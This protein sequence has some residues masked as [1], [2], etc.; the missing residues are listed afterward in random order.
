MHYNFEF[1]I[2]TYCQAKCPSCART[3]ILNSNSPEQLKIHHMDL[4]KFKAIVKD[5]A[6]PWSMITF[7]GEHGDPMMHPQIEDFIEE[8]FK[9][10]GKGV[11]VCTNGGLRNEIFY[12]KLAKNYHH[13]SKK[14]LVLL[15]GIDGSTHKVNN[16]YRIGVD[17]EQALKNLKA[18]KRHNGVGYW[19]YLIFDHNWKDIIPAAKLA[20]KIKSPIRFKF[21]DRD[22]PKGFLISDKNKEKADLILN[23]IETHYV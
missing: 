11:R 22:Y 23:K 3:L 9:R 21:N 7:C 2:T 20:K 18:Y 1:S 14:K 8:G 13:N 5:E 16:K 10:S 15:F 12:A 17:T 19:E 4:A 6:F